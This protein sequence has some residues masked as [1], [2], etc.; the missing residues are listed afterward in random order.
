MLAL[1]FLLNNLIPS[2]HAAHLTH[3]I[4]YTLRAFTLPPT[5]KE[6]EYDGKTHSVSINYADIILIPTVSLMLTL[7]QLWVSDLTF[8][9]YVITHIMGYVSPIWFTVIHGAFFTIYAAYR[10]KML[11]VM[12]AAFV[13][14]YITGDFKILGLYMAAAF[15]LSI[16]LITY[17]SYNWSICRLEHLIINAFLAEM[18]IW[19]MFD[20]SWDVEMWIPPLDPRSIWCLPIYIGNIIM[21]SWHEKWQYIDKVWRDTG[22]IF[23]IFNLC[24]A[25]W[26]LFNEII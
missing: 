14:R 8:V 5:I 1:G 22:F 6:V 18:K 10:P 9:P 12:K 17:E 16:H 20:K 21:R 24:I 19:L 26:L 4:W 3:S 2:D 7:P 13:S 15:H 25:A 11:F 23:I